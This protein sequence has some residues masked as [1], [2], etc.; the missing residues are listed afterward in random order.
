MEAMRGI[1]AVLGFLMRRS[2]SEEA[3]TIEEKALDT[4][5]KEAEEEG[6]RK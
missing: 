6:D 4:A 1:W 2:Q 3:V 5:K